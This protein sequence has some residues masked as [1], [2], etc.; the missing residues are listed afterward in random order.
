M[1]RANAT[2]IGD[3][4]NPTIA[5]IIG[6]P[7]YDTLSAV[8]LQLN[9]NPVSID[10]NLGDGHRGFLHLTISHAINNTLSAVAFSVHV[11]PG[12]HLPVLDPP[13]TAAQIAELLC[14]YKE[15]LASGA[16][17]RPWTRPSSI[18]SLG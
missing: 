5:P 3:F 4:P 18:S 12:L 1:N 6:V 17:I 9:Q 13:G 8:R 15:P 10:S 7:S 2:I 16:S 11:N 14:V